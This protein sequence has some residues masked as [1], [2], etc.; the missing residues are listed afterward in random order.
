MDFYLQLSKF[1]F[2]MTWLLSC[3]LPKGVPVVTS[4]VSVCVLFLHVPF[5][6]LSLLFLGGTQFT[7]VLLRLPHLYPPSTLY[8]LANVS[9]WFII[10]CFYCI[11]Q[12]IIHSAHVV[13]TAGKVTTPKPQEEGKNM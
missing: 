10:Q 9:K 5:L 7:S 3:C 12:S 6:P 11:F 8:P 2:H 4:P 1:Y 13:F